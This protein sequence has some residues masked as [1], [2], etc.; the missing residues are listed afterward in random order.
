[1]GAIGDGV[2]E[3]TCDELQVMSGS[4]ESQYCT[5]QTNIT[6]YVIYTGIE[7]PRI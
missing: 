3:Y 4:V 7:D 1:M 6:P 5:L 2:K